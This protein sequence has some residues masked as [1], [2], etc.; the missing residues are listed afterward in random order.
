[1]NTKNLKLHGAVVVALG[2]TV[3]PN[4]HVMASIYAPGKPLVFASEMDIPAGVTKIFTVGD[5]VG[6]G[7]TLDI[8]SLGGRTVN[9]VSPLEIRLTLTGGAT[10]TSTA[11]ISLDAFKCDYTGAMG[12][13]ATNIL[14]GLDGQT[15]ITFKMPNGDIAAS[16]PKCLLGGGAT[17]KVRIKLNSGQKDY[18][19]V[20][21]AQIGGPSP[22]ALDAVGSI[23]SFTQA[24]GL[25]MTQQSVTIDV[26]NPSF[27]QKFKDGKTQAEL[28]VFQYKLLSTQTALSFSDSSPYTLNS[29]VPTNILTN[30]TKLVVS[31]APLMAGGIVTLLDDTSDCMASSPTVLQDGGSKDFKRTA[32]SG[33]A[34][35]EG[36]LPAQLSDANPTTINGVKVCYTVDGATRVDKGS[37]SF[38]IET[39]KGTNLSPNLSVTDNVLTKFFK[40]GT[41][42]KVLNIP[43]PTNT[44]D[45]PFIRIYNMGSSSTKVYGAMYEQDDTDTVGGK[46]LG[47]N[48]ELAALDGSAV[49]VLTS[50]DLAKLFSVAD[51]KGRAWLQI[52]GDSQQVRV[53]ALVRSGGPGGT[54]VNMSDRVL[55]DGDAVYRSDSRYTKSSQ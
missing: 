25:T 49:K 31:G 7:I 27:S 23:V 55:G 6:S 19:I 29:V 16:S 14:N 18:G 10:F 12:K 13:N 40:N 17:N 44:Q 34:T 35:F 4:A 42:V 52:E 39:V 33:F 37:V 9:D 24:A 22:A 1:M 21:S 41:S 43:S 26:A 5:P 48:V 11:P 32:A 47:K 38:S 54:L 45:Q 36:I 28:G 20:V 2:L 46:Q 15:T 53:Q 51:W 3:I 50:A 30:N 8:S